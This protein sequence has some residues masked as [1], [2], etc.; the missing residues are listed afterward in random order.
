MAIELSNFVPSG[1]Y[2]SP[3]FTVKFNL[4]AVG[5][6]GVNLATLDIRIGEAGSQCGCA[7]YCAGKFYCR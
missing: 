7:R 3:D 4:L 2:V 5:C 1:E 6:D